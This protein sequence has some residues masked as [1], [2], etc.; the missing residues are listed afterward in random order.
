MCVCVWDKNFRMRMDDGS[1]FLSSFKFRD[2]RF[3]KFRLKCLRF[4]I[5]ASLKTFRLVVIITTRFSRSAGI[6]L[7]LLIVK[8][9][10]IRTSSVLEM[11]LLRWRWKII[12]GLAG[13]IC[14]VVEWFFGLC[15]QVV[16]RKRDLL[17]LKRQKL[18]SQSLRMKAKSLPLCWFCW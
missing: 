14:D 18:I 17:H 16:G 13:W 1:G 8:S 9:T 6:L 11:N 7:R 3:H 15:Q 10:E 2:N 12:D 4:A 5:K